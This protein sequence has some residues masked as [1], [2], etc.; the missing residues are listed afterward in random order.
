MTAATTA[1]A[2]KAPDGKIITYSCSISPWD[3]KVSV[4]SASVIP[5]KHREYW[6]EVLEKEGYR[7]VRVRV[8]EIESTAAKEV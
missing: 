4:I 7:C 6:K 3:S 8:E 2:I 5:A 1:W